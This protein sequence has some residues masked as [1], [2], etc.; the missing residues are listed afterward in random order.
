[1]SY[2]LIDLILHAIEACGIISLVFAI[3]EIRRGND[4][5]FREILSHY[6]HFMRETLQ[7]RFENN[8]NEQIYRNILLMLDQCIFSILNQRNK[9]K[10]SELTDEL[11]R[12]STALYFGDLNEVKEKVRWFKTE[13]FR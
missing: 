2:E 9:I 12:L 6:L 5:R 4:Q 3:W 10:M 8:E 7:K 13:L 11:S 1:M